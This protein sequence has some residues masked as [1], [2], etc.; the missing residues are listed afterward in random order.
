MLAY[1]GLKKE[2]AFEGEKRKLAELDPG[3]SLLIFLEK[4]EII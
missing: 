3:N 4:L 2:A 1:K